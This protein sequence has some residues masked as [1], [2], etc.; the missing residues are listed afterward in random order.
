MDKKT[1]NIVNIIAIV[2]VIVILGILLYSNL[3][4]P[5]YKYKLDLQKITFFSDQNII[6][7]INTLKDANTVYVIADQTLNKDYMLGNVILF[8]EIFTYNKKTV[9]SY[10]ID[11]DGS[12]TYTDTNQHTYTTTKQKCLSALVDINAPKIILGAVIKQDK[13]Q[14]IINKNTFFITATS[15]NNAQNENYYFLEALYPNISEAIQNIKNVVSKV[16][17]KQKSKT[18]I[19]N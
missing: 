13:P 9:L 8:T 19:P 7:Q 11:K 3:T 16:V 2:L 18:A 12:C 1:K 6:N 14:I 4:T 15:V 10:L 5:T 17:N